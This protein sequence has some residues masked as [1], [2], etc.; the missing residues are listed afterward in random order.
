MS[1]TAEEMTVTF[2]F[3]RSGREWQ[4]YVNADPYPR[5]HPMI[6]CGRGFGATKRVAAGRALTALFDDLHRREPPRAPRR[7]GSR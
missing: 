1:D 5:F 2:T 7:R 3:G 4:A 6:P